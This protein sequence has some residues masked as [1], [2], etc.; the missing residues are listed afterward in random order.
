MVGSGLSGD[1]SKGW[2][3]AFAGSGCRAETWA[4]S[5]VGEE[6]ELFWLASG[7]HPVINVR[8]VREIKASF[9]GLLQIT[10]WF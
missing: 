1:T 2:G 7:V 4:G 3:G 10:I 5:E 8:N 6:D 9:G